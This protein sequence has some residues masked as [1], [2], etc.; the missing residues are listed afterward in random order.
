MS[1]TVYIDESLIEDG[2]TLEEAVQLAE[3]ELETARK[4]EKSIT[5]KI[6]KEEDAT[7]V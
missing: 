3:F 2:L 1:Y 6:K 5:L 7:N 4:D